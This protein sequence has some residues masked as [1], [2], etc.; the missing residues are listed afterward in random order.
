MS[1]RYHYEGVHAPLNAEMADLWR[2]VD[3]LVARS[4]I[5]IFAVVNVG[6]TEVRHTLGRVPQH[7]SVI[8]RLDARVWQTRPATET[9]VYLRAN[10]S[11]LTDVYL[12]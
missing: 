3:A 5:Q 9:S 7:I 11:A 6:E 2:A 1:R 4:S 8:P 12:R 10:V